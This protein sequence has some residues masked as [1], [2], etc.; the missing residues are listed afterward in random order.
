MYFLYQNHKLLIN[1][2]DL[3]AARTYEQELVSHSNSYLEQWYNF[4][5]DPVISYCMA[6]LLI[7][8]G[9]FV[10]TLCEKL[11]QNQ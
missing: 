7:I 4:N 9:I 3:C 11:Y 6:V 5:K 2:K 1:Y 8:I 10:S